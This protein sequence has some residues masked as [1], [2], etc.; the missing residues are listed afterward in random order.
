MIRQT[1]SVV[2]LV[3][4][5][6]LLSGPPALQ[7]SQDAANPAKLD[8]AI[9][10]LPAPARMGEIKFEV[11]VKDADGKTLTDVDVSIQL[12]MTAMPSMKS[13]VK[14]KAEDGKYTATSQVTM[15]GAWNVTVT[16]KKDGKQLGEKKSTLTAK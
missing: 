7:A 4:G 5:G 16:V 15:A 8:I 9:K 1:L 14:M 11:T 3:L 13:D 2:A 6:A 12:V 10:T